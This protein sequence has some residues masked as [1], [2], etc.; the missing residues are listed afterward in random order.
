[1]NPDCESPPPPPKMAL[2]SAVQNE[3]D[4]NIKVNGMVTTSGKRKKPFAET[5]EAEVQTDKETIFPELVQVKREPVSPSEE[6][7][8]PC[9][10]DAHGLPE[11]L[12][13]LE[14]NVG[15]STPSKQSQVLGLLPHPD[16][17][18]LLYRGH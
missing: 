11:M 13:S 5:S 2:F 18:R 14:N 7:P 1:M 12:L 4:R 10:L 3:R 6:L 16:R 9:S 8:S 15:L 17:G